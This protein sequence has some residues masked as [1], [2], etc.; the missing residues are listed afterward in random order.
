MK[1]DIN[2]DVKN[3]QGV[4]FGID[5][6]KKYTLVSYY[7]LN[8]EAPETI[9]TV[10]GGAV[11]QI[12]TFLAKKR[13]IGQWFYG[14][15]AR[16]Q[17]SMNQ[18]VAVDDLFESAVKNEKVYIETEEYLAR[19]LLLIF[20]RKLLTMPGYLYTNSPLA[21]LVICV[22]HLNMDIVEMFTMIA[23]RLELTSSQILVIDRRESFYYYVL[24]QDPNI[25]L[26]EVMLYDY[27]DNNLTHC[28][29]TQ[30][31][32]S[33][34]KLIELVEGNDGLLMDNKDVEF[35][36][37]IEKTQEGK[38]ISAVYLIGDGFDGDWM[39]LSLSRLLSKRRVFSGKNLYSKGACY[40]GV[41]RDGKMNWPYLYLGDHELKLNLSL[42]VVCKNEMKF[43]S[44]IE[45]GESW[46]ET[47]GECEIILDGTPEIEF[48]IQ[49]LDS[50]QAMV[51]V[52][53][54][55]DMPPRENRTTRLRIQALPISDKEIKLTIKDLGFGEIVPASNR[56]WEHH[57]RIS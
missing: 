21:K 18:A 47:S 44:L 6:S 38:I 36:K 43:Y 30:N 8:M 55:H 33:T 40:A 9:S 49:K 26:H 27:S 3:S 5:I 45:A 31:L 10:M 32:N 48:W 11:Y 56:I 22:E 13:G 57:I 14:N 39:K 15:E 53:E 51:E 2:M 25:F 4:Y 28:L 16:S 1:E 12:P 46:Y 34:P 35:D 23:N 42:K 37:I 17:V 7:Q 29:L 52:L 41:I 50:R 19:D 54:L 20:F 24:N